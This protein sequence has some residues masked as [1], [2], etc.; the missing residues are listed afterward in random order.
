MIYTRYA[1]LIL[2][3]VLAFSAEMLRAQTTSPAPAA[4]NP[5]LEGPTINGTLTEW[6]I[7][8]GDPYSTELNRKELARNTLPPFVNEVRDAPSADGS[9]GKADAASADTPIPIGVIRFT[10]AGPIDKGTTI[11]VAVS[12]KE[13]RALG[14]WPP[15]KVRSAGILW[16]DVMMADKADS[17]PATLPDK[18]WIAPL[19]SGDNLRS[20][21]TTEPF[22]LYDLEVTY[23]IGL[24]LATTGDGQ[25]SVVQPMDATMHDLTFYKRDGSGHW[26]TAS[27][28]ALGKT[29]GSVLHAVEKPKPAAPAP[30][31]AGARRV[32][33]VNGR[34]V[35]SPPASQPAPA[36]APAT[37]PQGAQI[38]LAPFAGADAK[39]LSFWDARLAEAGVAAGDRDVALK[40]LG[41][42]AL[43]KTRLNAIYR[44]DPAELDKILPLEIVPQPTK[45]SRIAL[46]VLTNIDPAIETELD[47]QIARLGSRS[48]K[49]REAAMETIARM[50]E[51]AKNRLEKATSDKDTEIAYRAEQLL[52]M[53]NA[54]PPANE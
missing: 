1:A 53:L 16:Q 11:D 52:D 38:A 36:T 51:M 41:Q 42:Y 30:V 12:Y 47:E 33:I 3:A 46:V 54:A 13:G 4:T 20:G 17:G 32:V 44:M 18:S 29:A 10:P 35:I 8:V 31:V 40:I 26:K 25:Y 2:P 14:S 50:G 9:S 48:W 19:R 24:Q 6:V 7:F 28:S 23:P 27:I 34:A 43:D 5:A 39:I 15:A 49:E 22:L 37:Q 21:T 45:I